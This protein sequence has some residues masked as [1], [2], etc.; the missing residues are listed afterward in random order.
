LVCSSPKDSLSWD[1]I[2]CCLCINGIPNPGAVA[3]RYER[4]LLQLLGRDPHGR[5]GRCL[6]A[7][8]R[9]PWKF[10]TDLG[11]RSGCHELSGMGTNL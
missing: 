8:V 10:M 5:P 4:I 2:P 1:G 7:A 11:C 9:P 3:E 6:V